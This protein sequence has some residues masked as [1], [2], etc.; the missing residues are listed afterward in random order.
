LVN[1]DRI[2]LCRIK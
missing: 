1:D 2:N